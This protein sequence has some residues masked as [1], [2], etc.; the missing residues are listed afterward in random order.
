M[1]ELRLED[2]IFVNLPQ[3]H[4]MKPFNGD[5]KEWSTFI[6]CFKEIVH[7][8]SNSN[9]LR[10][11][12]LKQLLSSNVR[13]TIAEYLDSPDTYQEALTALEGRYGEPFMLGRA[14]F[15]AVTNAKPILKKVIIK[16]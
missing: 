13:A 11:A 1:Q 16:Y 10:L 15:A 9:A 2:R 7:N 6:S 14:H 5:P 4:D 8:A 12:R 3:Q